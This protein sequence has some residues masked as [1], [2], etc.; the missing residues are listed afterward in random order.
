MAAVCVV[1]VKIVRLLILFSIL[2]STCHCIFCA[3]FYMYTCLTCSVTMDMLLCTIS[4]V[5]SY[6][7]C[8]KRTN[9]ASYIHVTIFKYEKNLWQCKPDR[10]GE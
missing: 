5:G 8:Y 10:I 2:Y 3:K 6:W 7:Y 9:S 1:H 4:V